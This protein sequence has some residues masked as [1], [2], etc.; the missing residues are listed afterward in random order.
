MQVNFKR[1]FKIKKC[2]ISLALK[3][4]QKIQHVSSS[5]YYKKKKTKYKSFYNNSN[6]T[7]LLYVLYKFYMQTYGSID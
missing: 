2:K 6:N 4:L 5:Y 3:R 7:I 1:F